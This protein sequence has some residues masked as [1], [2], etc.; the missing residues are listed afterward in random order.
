LY[1]QDKADILRR[2]ASMKKT[3]IL[4]NRKAILFAALIFA[5]AASLYGQLSPDSIIG[6]LLED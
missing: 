1:C 5:L 6:K 3:A 4:N 2:E